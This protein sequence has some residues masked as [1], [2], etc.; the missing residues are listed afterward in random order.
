MTDVFTIL[1][2]TALR[3]THPPTDRPSG[4]G[5]TLGT[6]SWVPDETPPGADQEGNGVVSGGG[7]VGPHDDEAPADSAHRSPSTSA[8]QRS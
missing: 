6:P 8:P 2:R 1:R 7:L 4:R 3:L 5:G